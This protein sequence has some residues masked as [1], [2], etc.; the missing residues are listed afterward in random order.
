MTYLPNA[1]QRPL[2]RETIKQPCFLRSSIR[3]NKDVTVRNSQFKVVHGEKLQAGRLDRLHMDYNLKGSTLM[4]IG[5][6]C[7]DPYGL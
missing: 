1:K 3:N 6:C 4:Q 5:V 2:S 7:S